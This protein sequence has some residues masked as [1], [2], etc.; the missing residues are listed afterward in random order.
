MIAHLQFRRVTNIIIT[1][2]PLE[3][4]G[5]I[6]A[7][8]AEAHPVG[9]RAI[10]GALLRDLRAIS[11]IEPIPANTNPCRIVTHPLF[12]T[13]IQTPQRQLLVHRTIVIQ[14]PGFTIAL[15]LIKVAFSV[16]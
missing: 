15:S 3:G 13:L 1:I 10:I 11:P 2:R 6:T 8:L 14:P 16:A 4:E 5:A 9:R 12:A 7:F